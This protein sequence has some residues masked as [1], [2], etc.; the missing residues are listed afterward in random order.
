MTE[1]PFYFRDHYLHIIIQDV[2][3]QSRTTLEMFE[4][5]SF[6]RD[7][8]LLNYIVRILAALDEFDVVLE[9]SLTYG[10]TYWY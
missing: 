1:F 9:N 7:G 10:I 6:F 3:V 5:N 4:E 2:L 8:S